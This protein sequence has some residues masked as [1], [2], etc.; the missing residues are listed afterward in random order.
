MHYP[1]A[2]V[3]P[4]TGALICDAEVAETTHTLTV[5]RH[6]R[7]TARLVVRRLRGAPTRTG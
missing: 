1:G 2:V 7:V 5:R 6:G 3:E 4:D